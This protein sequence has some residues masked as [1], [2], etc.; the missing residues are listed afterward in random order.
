MVI[1]VHWDLEGNTKACHVKFKKR[2]EANHVIL[3]FVLLVSMAPGEQCVI[4]FSRAFP[5][6][7]SRALCFRTF[8]FC[9]SC[10][11]TGNGRVAKAN[12]KHAHEKNR[13][14]GG[15]RRGTSSHHSCFL[16]SYSLISPK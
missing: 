12:A 16:L 15:G 9:Q 4:S 10:I 8:G 6:V 14:G 3:D 13:D 11:V 2:A 5:F 7:S 1:T